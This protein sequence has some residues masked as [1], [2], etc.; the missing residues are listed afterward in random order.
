MACPC[1]P[2]EVSGGIAVQLLQDWGRTRAWGI[3]AKVAARAYTI[4]G[5]AVAV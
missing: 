1:H 2:C 4:P 5:L 3:R